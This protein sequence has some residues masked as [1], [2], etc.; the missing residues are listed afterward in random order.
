MD[1]CDEFSQ[2]TQVIE[3]QKRVLHNAKKKT[4]LCPQDRLSRDVITLNFMV[5]S[6]ATMARE[7]SKGTAKLHSSFIPEAYP[8]CVKPLDQL[9]PI[10]I[11]AL[12]LETHHR[13]SYLPVRAITPP[14]RMTGLLILVEDERRD[15]V[16]LQLY[17]QEEE[18]I[19]AA[20]DIVNQGMIL[21]IKE[22]YFK[23][24]ASGDYGL[25]VDHL[26][27]MINLEI[28]DHRVPKAWRP[29]LIEI[30]ESADTLKRKGNAFVGQGKYWEAIKE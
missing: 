9:K 3:A 1:V 23:V 6:M 25:R 21:I 2:L 22:P 13:G 5:S 27:D 26:S 20:T 30:E 8:P 28:D 15:A 4:G 10:A 24:T 7:E 11:R 17:Q 12:K 29:R 16:L 18:D 14:N 19:R